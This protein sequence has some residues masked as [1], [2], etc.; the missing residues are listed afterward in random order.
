MD[1]LQPCYGIG[2][3]QAAALLLVS[4]TP[5]T[6]KKQQKKSLQL[7]LHLTKYFTIYNVNVTKNEMSGIN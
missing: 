6:D 3:H 5:L 4:D 1:V 2:M 7:T